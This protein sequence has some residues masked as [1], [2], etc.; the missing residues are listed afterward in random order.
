M[1]MSLD[2]HLLTCL[3]FFWIKARWLLR[4]EGYQEK[5]KIHE[6]IA[7]EKKNYILNK[8]RKWI[9]E[10]GTEL[11][12]SVHAH[13][14]KVFFLFSLLPPNIFNII[15]N[16]HNE[17]SGSRQSAKRSAAILCCCCCIS[18]PLLVNGPNDG[19]WWP[20]VGQWLLPPWGKPMFQLAPALDR[21]DNDSGDCCCCCC[22]VQLLPNN[23]APQRND[24]SESAPP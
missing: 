2:G 10:I 20:G 21:L 3:F 1:R 18:A 4:L 24:A 16:F 17:L 22:C 12:N 9:K 5:K 11:Y 13:L 7:E 23:S 6:K 15:Y 14:R 19:L 8:K